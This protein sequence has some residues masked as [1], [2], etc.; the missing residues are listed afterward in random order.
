MTAW[1]ATAQ[2]PEPGWHSGP[3]VIAVPSDALRYAVTGRVIDNRTGQPISGATV[4]LSS[5]CLLPHVDGQPERNA[6]SEQVS[7]DPKGDFI[8]K[9]VPAMP[10]FVSVALEGY[11]MVRTLENPVASYNVSADVSP[12]TLSLAALP[13]ISGV[14][15][16]A[17]GEPIANAQVWLI[18][19]S[20]EAGWPMRT[21]HSVMR[22]GA[23]G[24]YIFPQRAPG[25]YE[26]IASV[27]HGFDP[28]RRDQQGRYVGYVPV[29][30]PNLQPGAPRSF[31]VLAEG[32]QA[33]ADL[34]LRE[35]V[36]H[37]ISGSTNVSSP[38]VQVL[39]SGGASEYVVRAVGPQLRGFEAWV[40]SGHFWLNS[41][42]ASVDGEFIGSLPVEVEDADIEGIVFTLVPKTS[43]T[44]PIVI[45]AAPDKSG[46]VRHVL[47]FRLH[48]L[49]NGHGG[50]GS[51]MTGWM[52][53]TG[54]RR[55]ERIA[56]L[57]G[58]YAIALAQSDN[59]YAQS[60]TRSGVDIIRE[61]LVVEP[62]TE[63][64]AI[65]VV[66]AE[67]ASVEGFVRRSGKP[68]RGAIYAVPEQPDGRLLQRVISNPDG[69]FR[70]DGLAPARYLFFASDAEVPLD[71]RT[72]A[73]VPAHWHQVGRSL[74]VEAGKITSL[75]LEVYKP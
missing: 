54:A 44:I 32:E 9:A 5:H 8:F 21:F 6:W 46:L 28:P 50:S 43:L 14:V 1:G 16:G 61:P 47:E 75:D 10:V 68:V 24:S 11:Q 69:K 22:T 38:I 62:G 72:A 67:G 71:V 56:A 2:T 58:S 26:L 36:L 34:E 64:D 63:Q 73:E 60:I 49:D 51:T 70:V 23:D 19:C 52:R 59:I 35:Q 4:S 27:P 15:R 74:T 7:S 55:T 3:C 45:S 31:L 40:P 42:F 53:D 37:R 17:D 20:S 41:D 30:Y 25:R 65:L 12:I 18:Y 48:P 33:R 13:S 57:P 66:V 39:D 29:R